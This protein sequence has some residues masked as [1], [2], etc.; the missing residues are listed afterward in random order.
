M[1]E[2]SEESIAAIPKLMERLYGVVSELEARFGD[3]HRHF[4]PDGHLVGSIGEV[5]AA[6]YYGLDL[7]KSSATR[8]D[9]ACFTSGRKV[10]VK[11]TQGVVIALDAREVADFLIAGKLSRDGS[12]EQF[13]NGPGAPAWNAAGKV[14]KTGQRRVYLSTLRRLDNDVVEADRIQ[15][16]HV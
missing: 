10:Q 9:G 16:I 4:T 6:Y 1:K 11:V 5:L 13:Y 2:I 3:Q 15:R 12:F 7:S 14:Q 8:H